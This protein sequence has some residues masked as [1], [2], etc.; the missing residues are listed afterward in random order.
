LINEQINWKQR[1]FV[2]NDET[3]G[4]D[5]LESL[6][7]RYP[8]ILTED[9]VGDRESLS[10]EL[11]PEVEISR[12]QIVDL[13]QWIV[14]VSKATQEDQSDYETDSQADAAEPEATTEEEPP[15][16]LTQEAAVSWTHFRQSE[17]TQLAFSFG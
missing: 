9:Q 5:I 17:Q 1:F 14:A 4:I 7:E 15:F 10:T 8:V 11:A 3:S 13:D 16:A 12:S 6:L 2:P